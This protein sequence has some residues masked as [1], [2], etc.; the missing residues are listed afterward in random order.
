MLAGW[1]QEA[2]RTSATL[3]E[4][5]AKHKDQTTAQIASIQKSKPPDD[6]SSGGVEGMSFPHIFT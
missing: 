1:E 5:D 2:S 4:E 3:E 6:F